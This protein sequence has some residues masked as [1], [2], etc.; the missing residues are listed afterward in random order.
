MGEGFFTHRTSQSYFLPSDIAEFRNSKQQLLPGLP[1]GAAERTRFAVSARLVAPPYGTC[2][3]FHR[4]SGR[5]RGLP[6]V[7]GALSVAVFCH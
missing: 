6:W 2:R 1:A 5:C 4:I 7:S 3:G